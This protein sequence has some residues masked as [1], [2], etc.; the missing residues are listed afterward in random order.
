MQDRNLEKGTLGGHTEAVISASEQRVSPFHL[1]VGHYELVKEWMNSH[2][3]SGTPGT[4]MLPC[5]V[6]WGV[7]CTT[8]FS[9]AVT[10]TEGFIP[11]PVQLV[12]GKAG[13]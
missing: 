6:E 10:R 4:L 8:L 3:L 7:L 11:E 9:P 5:R 2:A 12:S 13:L 1:R